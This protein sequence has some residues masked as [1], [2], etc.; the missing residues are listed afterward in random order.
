MK[1]INILKVT[2]ERFNLNNCVG[3]PKPLIQI[4]GK[5]LITRWMEQLQ[6]LVDKKYIT[7]ND[8]FVV[9]NNLY[10]K[11]FLNWS[12]TVNLSSDQII[13]DMTSDNSNR[14]GAVADIELVIQKKNIKG[15][16]IMIIGGDTLF[17]KDFNIISIVEEHFKHKKSIVLSYKIKNEEELSKYG[18]LQIDQKNK[19]VI[20]FL[21]KPKVSKSRLAC[22]CFYILDY[23]SISLISKFLNEI[24]HLEKKDAPGHFIKYLVNDTNNII[25]T[26]EI[27]KRFDIGNLKDLIE[28]NEYFCSS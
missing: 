17:D 15:E 14:I 19:R 22:P 9:T 4:G 8:I 18:I 10:Y 1:I 5:P 2:R 16:S 23:N 6:L 3:I 21:E 28:T 7:R 20:K 13:N 26:I 12:K 11:Q 24:Q 27:S 25:L